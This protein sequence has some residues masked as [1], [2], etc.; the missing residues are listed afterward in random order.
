MIVLMTRS[1]TKAVVSMLVDLQIVEATQN[2]KLVFI[3]QLVNVCLDSL[4]T[5]KLH[6]H[7]VSKHQDKLKIFHKEIKS[8]TAS[9][10]HSSI[11]LFMEASLFMSASLC[12]VALIC[13]ISLI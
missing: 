1:V 7:S 5:Q 11:L 8:D 12:E 10:F 4:A 13:E 3:Q 9:V 6:V 2:V